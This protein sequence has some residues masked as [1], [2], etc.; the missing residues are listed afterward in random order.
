MTTWRWSTRVMPWRSKVIEQ[1]HVFV[2]EPQRTESLGS[3]Y[4]IAVMSQQLYSHCRKRLFRMRIS[5]FYSVMI[6][7]QCNIFPPQH[8]IF[9]LLRSPSFS[10]RVVHNDDVYSY[11]TPTLTVP[12][13]M[14]VRDMLAEMQV[15][16]SSLSRYIPSGL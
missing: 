10:L 13:A 6:S 15:L 9:T 8:C 12:L 2:E 5:P 1:N 11:S 16:P 7:N 4:Q 14:A 3:E